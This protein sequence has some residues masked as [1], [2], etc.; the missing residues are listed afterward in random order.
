MPTKV[1]YALHNYVEFSVLNNEDL[2]DVLTKFWV[3][4]IRNKHIDVFESSFIPT[5]FYTNTVINCIINR[6]YTII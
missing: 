2:D 1:F 6:N 4:N 5:N 3:E